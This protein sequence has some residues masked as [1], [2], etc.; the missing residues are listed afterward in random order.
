M[1]FITIRF[2]DNNHALFNLNCSVVNLLDNIRKRSNCDREAAID[3][4]DEEGNV[5]RLAEKLNENAIT[6]LRQ[7]GEYVLLRVEKCQDKPDVYLSLLNGLEYSNPVLFEKL[8]NTSKPEG[9]QPKQ[10]IRKKSP[11]DRA[12]VRKLASRAREISNTSPVKT[13]LSHRDN[14]PKTDD[15]ISLHSGEKRTAKQRKPALKTL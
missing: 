14:T 3:L 13:D 11:W 1:S 7:R 9:E 15:K 6:I 12:G 10:N 4:T 5:Q 2:G 8:Q